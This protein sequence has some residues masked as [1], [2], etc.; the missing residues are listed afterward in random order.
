MPKHPE[1]I[2]IPP[3]IDPGMHDKNSRPLKLFSQAKLDTLLSN[4]EHPAIKTLSF[5]RD[6]LLKFYLI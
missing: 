4:I 5:N 2:L 3:P 6:I 1:F